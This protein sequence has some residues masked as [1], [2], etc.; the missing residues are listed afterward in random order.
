M[1]LAVRLR[2]RSGHRMAFHKEEAM[3]FRGSDV[4]PQRGPR[5][6]PD[7]RMCC[8]SEGSSSKGRDAL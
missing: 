8:G 5:E 7:L 4:S 1:F 2:G 6:A 3:R